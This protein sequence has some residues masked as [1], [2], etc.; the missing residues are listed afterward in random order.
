MQKLDYVEALQH[1]HS[2]LD[3]SNILGKIKTSQSKVGNAVR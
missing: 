1:L 2:P 3:A